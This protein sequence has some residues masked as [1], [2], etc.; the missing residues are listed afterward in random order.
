MERLVAVR[1]D[2]LDS[3]GAALNEPG[4][5]PE[6]KIAL[7]GLFGDE[8]AFCI[9]A[10]VIEIGGTSHAGAIV[11]VHECLE[12]LAHDCVLEGLHCLTLTNN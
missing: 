2:L 3:A 4:R 5:E 9:R 7:L 1:I 12:E 6:C 10:K 11:V 8:I